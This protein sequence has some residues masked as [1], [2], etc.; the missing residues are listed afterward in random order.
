MRGTI[1]FRPNANFA[2]G[3][4]RT[5][6]PP[7]CTGRRA[8]KSRVSLTL[9]KSRA[10]VGLPNGGRSFPRQR[11]TAAER[12]TNASTALRPVAPFAA[13]TVRVPQVIGR[14]QEQAT[15]GIQKRESR[16]PRGRRDRSA[17]ILWRNA[18][19]SPADSVV[20]PGSGGGA[21][22]GDACLP[23][24]VC[25]GRVDHSSPRH[26]SRPWRRFGSPGNRATGSVRRILRASGRG[27]ACDHVGRL[28]SRPS[29]LRARPHSRDGF[30]PNRRRTDSSGRRRTRSS[31]RFV[32]IFRPSSLIPVSIA[33]RDSCPSRARVIQPSLRLAAAPQY[34]RVF[35]V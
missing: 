31:R 9:R 25:P 26:S 6:R 33:P 20:R 11:W 30:R 14:Y 17:C 10:R 28:S 27:G 7:F 15:A 4:V 8:A 29:R 2:A 1:G 19:A 13:T 22:R 32:S 18:T 5:E 35:G 21:A 34:T 24:G 12:H 16:E 23:V 3:F